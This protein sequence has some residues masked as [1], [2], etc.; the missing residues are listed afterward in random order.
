MLSRDDFPREKKTPV[1]PCKDT[2]LTKKVFSCIFTYFSYVAKLY[3]THQGKSYFLRLLLTRTI[4]PQTAS[5]FLCQI[6]LNN[7]IKK[8]VDL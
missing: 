1:T 3:D 5:T 8:A 6:T 2:I 7:Q 4:N